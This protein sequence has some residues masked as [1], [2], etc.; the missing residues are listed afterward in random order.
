MRGSLLGPPGL[1]AFLCRAP[2]GSVVEKLAVCCWWEMQPRAV[3][4][5]AVGRA[6]K[7]SSAVDGGFM[8]SL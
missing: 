1:F 4:G 2:R 3:H 8:M 7:R 5:V 6:K